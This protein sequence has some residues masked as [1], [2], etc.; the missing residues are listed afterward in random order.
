VS[1]LGQQVT[2]TSYLGT[3][4]YT[5]RI[6]GFT[7]MYQPTGET[8][9]IPSTE[10]G[11]AGTY[12]YTFG[13][14][15]AGSDLSSTMP[16][17]GGLPREKLTIGYN[18]LGEADTLKTNVSPT[19][20]DIFVVNGTGYTRYGELG[21]ISRRS[22]D[23][24][25]LDTAYDYETGTRRSN[26]IHTT[27]ET[28]PSEVSDVRLDY[29]A[30]GNVVKEQ[31]TV[32]GDTQC[33]GYDYARRLTEA[34]TPASAD[35]AAARSQSQLAGPAPY[36]NSY[37]FDAVGNRASSTERT[38]ASSVSRSYA[39]PAAKSS[40]PHAL[41]SMT[42]TGVGTTT[43]AYDKT[44]STLTRPAN[45]TS[46]PAQTLAW[47]P[48]G[49]LATS[50]DAGGTTTYV[51]DAA[52]NRIIK[53]EPS[54]TTLS[55]PG[56]E[57]RVAGGQSTAT[58]YLS[59]AGKT[60]A[61]RTAAGLTWQVDDQQGTGTIEVDA[62]T[63]AVTKRWLTPFGAERGTA[64]PWVT[65]KGLVGGTKDS[66]GLTHLGAREY[67]PTIGRFISV[68]PAIASDDP[69]QM[70][71]YNY[72][73][74]SPVTMSDPDGR[75][76]KNSNYDPGPVRKPSKKALEQAKHSKPYSDPRWDS[77]GRPRHQGVYQHYTPP[78][79]ATPY[80]SPPRLSWN[81]TNAVT[82]GWTSLG[83]PPYHASNP[84]SGGYNSGWS[85]PAACEDGYEAAGR[86]NKRLE[87]DYQ[88]KLKQNPC[89][90]TPGALCYS[91]DPPAPKQ[92]DPMH[93]VQ[94]EYDL[95]HPNAPKDHGRSQWFISISFCYV[96]CISLTTTEDGGVWIGVSGLG[97]PKS[98]GASLLVGKNAEPIDDME[99]YGVQQC[100]GWVGGYC[101]QM[102][103]D[104]KTG[105]PVAGGGLMLTTSPTVSFGPTLGHRLPPPS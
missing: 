43:Y 102:G 81:P 91:P 85:S 17:L 4:A 52:G 97:V 62:I 44:G 34:W 18:A 92:V 30:S 37:T 29:D 42:T 77:H 93:A 89:D 65:D 40:Q 8:I 67:D 32:A 74:A 3:A 31:E 57:L 23:G 69:Q 72:A 9:T 25:W 35:C 41:Q 33:F 13:Y 14:T 36:W 82:N 56:Q 46:G 78:R 24:R 94:A 45:G 55:L 26:R 5:T 15:A 38:T 48:D 70:Q 98:A 80:G 99:D 21:L 95:D 53:R 75:M 100:A 86:V 51:Y 28:T 50:T 12:S 27:R 20:D 39:Y 79:Y 19:G 83:L 22:G 88:Q 96:G 47:N 90:V 6:D 104:T 105:K 49:T 66:S 87:D 61:V 73:N 1:V 11:L 2:S 84:C 76:Y 64:V 63:Q 10:T 59:H 101:A 7:D 103:F 58:R 68:D 16:A 71:G 60:V 54:G